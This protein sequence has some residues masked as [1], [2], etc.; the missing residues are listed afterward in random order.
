[1]TARALR[2]FFEGADQFPREGVELIQWFEPADENQPVRA[3][4]GAGLRVPI[5]LL[6]SSLFSAQLAGQ[7]GLPYAF[8]SHFAPELLLE[9]LAL[10]RRSFTP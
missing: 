10:Y 1:A 9:A 3:V 8:A 5:W 4:P 6:G 7:L 2:R